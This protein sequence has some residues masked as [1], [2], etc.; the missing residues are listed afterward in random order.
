MENRV[1]LNKGTSHMASPL[2]NDFCVHEVELFLPAI[3][4]IATRVYT[5][6]GK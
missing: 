5:M 3:H 4:W 2:G 1:G 6:Y